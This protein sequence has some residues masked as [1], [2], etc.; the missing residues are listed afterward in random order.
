MI[1][2]ATQSQGYQVGCRELLHI[3]TWTGRWKPQE[4][5][6]GQWVEAGFKQIAEILEFVLRTKENIL[7]GTPLP[8]LDEATVL[9]SS[10]LISK[11]F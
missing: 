5:L 9:S 10:L 11:I 3:H 2:F 6:V 8:R 7:R 4:G 1:F